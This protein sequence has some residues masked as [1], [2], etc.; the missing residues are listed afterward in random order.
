MKLYPFY[1]TVHDCHKAT[2]LSVKKEENGK[3]SGVE[4]FQLFYHLL[5]CR[6]CRRFVKQ[7][8]RINT[9]GS[10]YT[11][12]IQINPPHTLS[13]ESKEKMQKEMEKH[14]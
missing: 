11:G 14:L 10:N 6:I 1:T 8:R 9:M 3:L 12:N 5:W 2:Q 7:I 4:K 13:I